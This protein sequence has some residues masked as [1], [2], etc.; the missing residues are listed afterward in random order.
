VCRSNPIP[1]Q[2]ITQPHWVEG[3]DPGNVDRRGTQDRH[4]LIVDRDNKLLYELYH[5]YYNSTTGGWEADSGAFWDMKVNGRRT[6]GWTSAD[7]AGLAILPGLVRYDEVYDP[8]VTEIQH[9][10]RVTVRATNGYVYPAS[11]RAGSTTGALPMGAR[12]RL[13]ASKDISGFS[14]EM[15]KIFRA[16]KRYGLIVADNG[17]DMYITGT[18]DTRWNNDVLNP[19]FAALTASDFEVVK[20]GWTPAP[21]TPVTLTGLA[22]NPSTVVGGSSTTGTVTLSA[23]APTGGVSVALSS[24]SSAVASVP[25]SVSVGSGSTSASFTVT[26]SSVTTTQVVGLTASLDGTDKTAAV[27]VTPSPPPPP[28]ALT[29]LTLNP[30]SAVRGASSVGTVK[31]T[32]AAPTGGIVVTLSSSKPTQATVPPSV[33]VLAG[34]STATF[35]VSTSSGAGNGAVTISASANGITKTASLTIKRK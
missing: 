5:V 30:T 27:T 2:A 4:L 29:S 31:L 1:T 9:A 17:S 23:G 33:T 14:P 34:Q 32:A 15:Q 22:V 13:K 26:T 6:E 16:M 7:A 25:A 21:S 24:A 28:P 20:L 3:G 11:H 19:A 10:F 18:F 35:T 8:A 12:L